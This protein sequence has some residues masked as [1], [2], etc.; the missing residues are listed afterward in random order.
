MAEQ[1]QVALSEIEI[2]NEN[3]ALNVM[4]AMINIAQKRG[5]YSLE[6]SSKCWECVR[7]FIR[8]QK[9]AV[10]AESSVDLSPDNTTENV[11]MSS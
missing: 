11:V 3:T 4:V 1:K 7:M 6:E 2:N 8:Q 5:A 9:D 10:D